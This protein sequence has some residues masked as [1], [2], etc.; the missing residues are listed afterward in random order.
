LDRPIAAITAQAFADLG[1]E[2]GDL[3]VMDLDHVAE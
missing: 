1:L 2:H 3:T